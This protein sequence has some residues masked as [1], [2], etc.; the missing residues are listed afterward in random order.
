MRTKATLSL[1]DVNVLLALLDGDHPDHEVATNWFDTPG[2]QWALCPFTEA[3]MLRYLTAPKAIGMSM[4]EA[5]EILN[6]WKNWRGYHYVALQ[7]DWQTVTRPFSK[8]LQGHN[9]ITDA[10]LLGTAIQ[11]KIV[12]VTFDKG[13]LHMGRDFIDHV[14]LL[15]QEGLTPAQ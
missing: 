1:V 14:H 5:T 11:K 6:K 4:A 8:H 2:M 12:L 3:A 9:Q 15:S 7:E 13:F 10:F